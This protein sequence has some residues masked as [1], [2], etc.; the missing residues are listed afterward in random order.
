MFIHFEPVVLLL[1]SYPKVKVKFMYKTYVQ[2]Y[3]SLDE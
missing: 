2:E 1:A 3:S